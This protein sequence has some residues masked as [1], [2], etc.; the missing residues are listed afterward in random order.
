ME[1]PFATIAQKLESIEAK[2]DRLQL[3]PA[4]TPTATTDRKMTVPEVAAYLSLPEPTIRT[5]LHKRKIPHSK[6][7]RRILFSQREIDN[8]LQSQHRKT[9]DEIQAEAQTYLNRRK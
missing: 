4:P 2:L 6:V 8:W 9:S 7:G 3:K 1:N 5:F